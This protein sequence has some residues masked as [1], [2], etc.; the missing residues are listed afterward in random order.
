MGI[1]INPRQIIKDGITSLR[2]VWS[3]RK[4]ANE[5]SGKQATLVSGTNIKTINNTSL[6]GSGDIV[7]NADVPKVDMTATTATLEPNKFYVWGEVASLDI[8]LAAETAGIENIYKF[9]FQSGTTAT[10]LTLP[11]SVSIDGDFPNAIKTTYIVSIESNI[12]KIER[13]RK[14]QLLPNA[15]QQVEYLECSG[16]QYIDVGITGHGQYTLFVKSQNI[17]NRFWCFGSKISYTN[18]AFSMANG[19]QQGNLYSDSFFN[20][21]DKWWIRTLSALNDGLIHEFIC[22]K[23]TFV[24]DDVQQ[25]SYEVESFDNG[26]NITLFAMNTNGTIIKCTSSKIYE[27]WIKDDSTFLCHVYPCYRKSDNV[28]GMYDIVRDVFLTNVGTG[29]FLV[30]PDV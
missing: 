28:A 24:I 1:I 15:Y 17:P 12:A 26:I 19:G 23:G 5:L 9:Q 6:L 21:G 2:D 16:S 27:S 14:E 22:D 25:V 30:G 11:S 13:K 4:V 8:S 18:Q 20:Y 7:I 29:T 10:T 3:S